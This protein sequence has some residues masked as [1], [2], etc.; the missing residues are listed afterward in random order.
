MRRWGL[1]GWATSVAEAFVT[2]REVRTNVARRRGRARTLKR[3]HG[4]P[5]S[6]FVWNMGCDP[7]VEAIGGPI[8]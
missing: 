5:A 1:P 6:T 4:G 7:I 3:G 8:F 2:D